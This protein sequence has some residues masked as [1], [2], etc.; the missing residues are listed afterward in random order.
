MLR[1]DYEKLLAAYKKIAKGNVRLTQS[2]L[3]LMRLIDPATTN[4]TFPVLENETVNGAVTKFPEEQRLNINDQFAVTHLGVYFGCVYNEREPGQNSANAL[5]YLSYVP[6][7]LN[8]KMPVLKGLYAGYLKIDVNNVNFVD[9]WNLMKHEKTPHTQFASYEQAAFPATQPSLDFKGDGIFPVTP[10]VVLSGAKK[11]NIQIF[12]PRAIANP[13]V[14]QWKVGD[15][16]TIYLEIK[17]IV[18][19]IR[20][21]LAQNA[22]KFQG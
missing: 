1:Y 16:G 3:V 17:Y 20:G 10:N 11:N 18:C 15:Q 12:L 6:M 19:H 5:N 8:S 9:K 21:F 14:T 7:E 22:S 13:G 2:D 4:Y